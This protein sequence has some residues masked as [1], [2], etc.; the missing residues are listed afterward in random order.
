MSD[1]HKS[2]VKK[3]PDCGETKPVAEFGLNKRLSDGYARYC[4]ACF[5]VRSRAS[6]RKRRAEQGKQVREARVVPAGSKYC[7]G[8]TEIKAL[9]EFGRNRAAHD[10]LTDY[11]KPCHNSIM[12]EIR[13]RKHGSA[14]NYHLKRRYGITADEVKELLATQGGICLRAP[15]VHVDHNHET[16]LF[17]GLLCF[18][19]NGAL[20][21]FDD[22]SWRLRL[23]ADYLESGVG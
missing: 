6:Y 21:Q 7:P 4:K 23:A 8:C 9:E 3:C 16:G 11:C 18:S 13:R 22:E 12:A 17:R 19:C 2:P 10:G 14:R 1:G 15:A 5:G 20:G